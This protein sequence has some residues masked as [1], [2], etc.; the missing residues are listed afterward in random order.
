M[1]FGNSVADI[2]VIKQTQ[3]GFDISIVHCLGVVFLVLFS[4]TQC[5]NH[6]LTLD[7]WMDG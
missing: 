6:M 5:R 7:V 1:K 3:F 4:W 2:F